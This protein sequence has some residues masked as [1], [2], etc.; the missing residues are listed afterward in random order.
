MHEDEIQDR[1]DDGFGDGLGDDRHGQDLRGPDL[2]ARP[3]L[4]AGPRRA[5]HLAHHR[6]R[7]L[8]VLIAGGLAYLGFMALLMMAMSSY[9]SNK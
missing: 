7:G 8:A 3:D 5:Q 6:R 1:H 2:R 9:G 4:A